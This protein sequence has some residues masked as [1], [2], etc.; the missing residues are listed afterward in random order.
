VN[1]IPA[2]SGGVT[3]GGS[4][5]IG[6]DF[7]AGGSGSP[8][9]S[10]MGGVQADTIGALQ[11]GSSVLA[12]MGAMV[13]G[14]DK[15]TSL[16]GTA[17]S[18]MI[19]AGEW[20]TQAGDE[21]VMGENQ[22]TG[23][24]NQYLSAVSGSTARMGA[25]GVDVGQG[26]GTA[27]RTTLATNAVTGEQNDM[28]ASQI[29]ANRDQVNVMQ[30][31]AGASNANAAAQEDQAAGQSGL[32]GGLLTGGIDLLKSGVGQQVGTAVMSALPA[33]LAL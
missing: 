22:V 3:G 2:L 33:L 32:I 14:E 21:R 20:T 9:S 15:A 29:R 8:G 7:V 19:Q 28:L 25:S 23:L 16:R 11:A 27:N 13:Q 26:V 30:A 31:F 17:T 18:D 6:S 4:G 12:G 5:G 24:K 1:T 10:L